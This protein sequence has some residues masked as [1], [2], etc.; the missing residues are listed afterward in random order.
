MIPSGD[1]DAPSILRRA[2]LRAGLSLRDLAARAE[3]SHSTLAAYEAARVTPSVETF[4]RV[5]SAAGFDVSLSLT[6]RIASDHERGKELSEAL[7]LAA[8][9][10]ARHAPTLEFPVFGRRDH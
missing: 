4:D 1:M 6:L 7:V 3:T 8:Q 5:L 10:P 2:R 9:F